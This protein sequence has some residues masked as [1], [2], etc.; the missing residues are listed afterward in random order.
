M[1]ECRFH[2]LLSFSFE[3]GGR[4][5][6]VSEATRAASMRA[7]PLV[8]YYALGQAW[9]VLADLFQKGE[10][11]LHLRAEC[12]AKPFSFICRNTQAAEAIG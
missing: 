4:P 1:R 5:S 6:H 2:F 7:M 12:P 9:Q 3:A 8:E 10:N 11:F